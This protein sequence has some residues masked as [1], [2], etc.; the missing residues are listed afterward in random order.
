MLDKARFVTLI[1]VRKLDR[2]IKFYIESLGGKLV[3]R[4]E[5]EMKDWFASVK[6][7]R[8]EFWLVVP[9]K[10]EKRELA[11]NAFIVDDIKATVTDLRANGVRFSRA[12]KFGTD[13]K[14]EGPIT[15]HASGAEAF[16][17]DS[18]GNLIMLWQGA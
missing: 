7:G 11:Y 4:G 15:R 18:E 16:F 9:E 5:G 3:E 8:N 14:I 13:T 6:V 12:E 17:K 10:W 2:A 1:T